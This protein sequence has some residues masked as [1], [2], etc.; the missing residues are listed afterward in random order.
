MIRLW[1]SLLLAAAFVPPLG[2]SPWKLVK[3]TSSCRIYSRPMEG[4]NLKEWQAVGIFNAD[5]DSVIRMMSQ[6]DRYSEW[7]GMC[8][9]LC[10]IQSR[11]EADFDLYF[12]LAL[13][14]M[15]DRDIV[16]NVRLEFDKPGGVAQAT[17]RGVDSPYRRDSGLVRMPRMNGT[18]LITRR[19]AHRTEVVY[20]YFVEL[21]GRV[22][23]SFAN[24]LGW[25]QPAETMKKIRQRV[26]CQ[27]ENRE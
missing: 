11:S 26:E 16:A 22:H 7:F 18:I 23:H 20:Q 3:E 24:A 12:A 14:L 1:I 17:F 2:A 27:G 8:R 25:K 13:P 10:L 21:G 4:S 9:E 5:F 6:R 19:G 15:T